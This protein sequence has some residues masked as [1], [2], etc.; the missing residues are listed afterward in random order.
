VTER[1]AVQNAHKK[2]HAQKTNWA[3]ITHGLGSSVE[4][5][6]GLMAV[7]MINKEHDQYPLRDLPIQSK[8]GS[9]ALLVQ[10][11]SDSDSYFSGNNSI[12]E[13]LPQARTWAYFEAYLALLV[14]VPTGFYMTTG[15]FGIKHL[16]IP[17]FA[18]FGVLR[19]LEALRV[20]FLHYKLCQNLWI[21][22][23]VGTV[24]RLLGYFVLPYSS[25]EAQL[26]EKKNENS[27]RGDLFTEPTIYSFNILLSGYLTAAFVYPPKYLLGTLVL[28]AAFYDYYPHRVHSA[29]L[30][31]STGF[32]ESSN[33][34]NDESSS[35]SMKKVMKQV[36]KKR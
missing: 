28:Y 29:R 20:L 11:G 9:P 18:L 34:K 17:G 35:I 14:N 4:F 15:V 3:A 30:T 10:F 5:A 27:H 12:V 25:V 8:P 13:F 31:S 32:S 7:L 2:Y 22:L 16:T 6:I 23:H 24:V 26:L 1:K 21:L 19:A 36:M 33:A